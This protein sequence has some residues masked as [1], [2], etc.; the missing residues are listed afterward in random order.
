MPFAAAKRSL[1]VPP[2][3]R[4][5]DVV[6]S[7]FL[8][9]LAL[10]LMAVVALGVKVSS[11]GTVFYMSERRGLNGNSF[12]MIKFRSMCLDADLQQDKFRFKIF[13]DPR[14]TRLGRWIR[15]SSIDE[16]PQL[17]NVLKGD[18]SLVG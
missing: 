18:M 1:V 17:W 3:K 2:S 13:N 12:V 16:M 11:S 7:A 8:L 15:R 5:F 9:I 4:I 6:L 14:V 10:P